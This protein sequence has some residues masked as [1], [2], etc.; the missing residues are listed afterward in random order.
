M[1]PRAAMKN[2]RKVIIAA[3]IRDFISRT[4]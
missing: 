2:I 4:A 1:K 3:V